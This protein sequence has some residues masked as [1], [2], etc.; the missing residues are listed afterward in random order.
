MRL[1]D[2]LRGTPQRALPVP[3][4]E[5]TTFQQSWA[6][7]EVESIR[8]EFPAFAAG[9]YGGNGVVFALIHARLA[10]FSQA[11]FKF[12]RLSDRKLWGDGS[13]ALL[14]NP[15]PGGT[16]AELLARMEQDVSLAGNAFVARRGTRLERLRPDWVDIVHMDVDDV[17]EVVGYIY[18]CDGR[19]VGE[20][21]FLPVD[22]VAHWSPIPDPLAEFRGMSWLTPVVREIN[23]DLAM[24][25][26]RSTFFANAAT[27][28]L[29]LK[30]QQKLSKDTVDALRERWQA[31]YG[32]PENG[33]KTAVLD[34]GADLSVVGSSFEAMAF[35]D[36]QAAGENRLCMAAGVPPIVIGSKE[37]LSAATYSNYQQAL[38]AFGLGTMAFL[39][40]SAAAA[41]AKLVDVPSGN[42][43]WYDTARIPALRDEETARAEAATRMATAAA[44]FIQAGYEPNSVTSALVAGDMSLLV[45]TG[46]VSVQLQSP[47]ASPPVQP[48]EGP[49]KGNMP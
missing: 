14:E 11:E 22:D 23:A 46:L 1:I 2:R 31:R 33:W 44:S 48:V 45:H 4:P 37:G 26:H 30:Y 42:R 43:L 28:N 9:G 16:T 8:P 18:W 39:W 17:D 35:V 5:Y 38:R 36:V 25:D 15:W 19:G 20:S 47:G 24:T 29:V 49:M 3:A 13:L 21:E 34:E 32:G 27:P 7:R 40:Q 41:L 6:S 10:L 12:Q